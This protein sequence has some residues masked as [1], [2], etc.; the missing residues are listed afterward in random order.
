MNE[1]TGQD[2]SEDL[3]EQI[4]KVGAGEAAKVGGGEALFDADATRETTGI[5]GGEVVAVIHGGQDVGDFLL[6]KTGAGATIEADGNQ[7][8]SEGYVLLRPDR[9][10]T[11]GNFR[12]IPEKGPL[13]LSA[14]G[15]R[16]R[17]AF[18]LTDDQAIDL[19]IEKTDQGLSITNNGAEVR[20][21]TG[22]ERSDAETTPGATDLPA[23][24]RPALA[25]LTR[26]TFEQPSE[27]H[28]PETVVTAP[29]I[30]K[31]PESIREALVSSGTPEQVKKQLTEILQI[32]DRMVQAEEVDSLWTE[33]IQ[34]N[35][36]G[37]EAGL[38]DARRK[39]NYVAEEIKRIRPNFNTL[40]IPTWTPIH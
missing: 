7:P 24:A 16:N 31:N 14:A 6:V 34:P 5:H 8:L 18:G 15:R 23:E 4:K 20:I 2:H 36:G 27:S 11:D 17:L 33:V 19:S 10:R 21:Q 39:L 30:F 22:L 29:E 38:P 25:G 35:I 28:A 12:V 37:L 1:E 13:E 40:I 26:H 3:H 9:D 32:W